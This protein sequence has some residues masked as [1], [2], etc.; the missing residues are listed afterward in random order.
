MNGNTNNLCAPI[1]SI[2]FNEEKKKFLI[3]NL[4]N[5]LEAEDHY[6][7]LNCD[8]FGRIRNYQYFKLHLSNSIL[9]VKPL[10]RTLKKSLPF[11]TQVFQIMGCNWRCW[12]CFVDYKLLGVNQKYGHY[13]TTNELLELYLNN[14]INETDIIDL[15]G[16]QPDLIPEW[17]LNF[18]RSIDDHNLS[19]KIH[20]WMDDSLSSFNLWR[21]LSKTEIK[22]LSAFPLHSR[23]CCLK[24]YNEESFIYNTTSTKIHYNN[25]FLILDKLIRDGFDLYVY[26]NFTTP[27]TREINKDIN[28]FIEKL[29]RIHPLLPL[30]TIPLKVTPF[31]T[32]S[33]RL[34]SDFNVALLNQNIIFDL[35]AE[36]LI[37]NFGSKM[38]QEPY[39]NVNVRITY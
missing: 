4:H 12:Y 10:L 9:P 17:C 13:F 21:Y 39:E 34:K 2:A 32:M 1:R 18:A 38:V 14:S 25:Q 35:W 31:S 22:Y 5:T 29:M 26:V 36:R 8:G 3:S 33:K 23:A 24:G 6:T 16:G 30:R 15:S 37:S 19:G 20:L 28:V 7:S 27:S 11:K